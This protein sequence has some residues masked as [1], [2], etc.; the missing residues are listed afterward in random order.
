MATEDARDGQVLGPTTWAV[1]CALRGGASSRAD[2]CLVLQGRTTVAGVVSALVLLKKRGLVD[3]P[4]QRGQWV[5][6]AAGAKARLRPPPAGQQRHRGAKGQKK[7]RTL[8]ARRLTLREQEEGRALAHVDTVTRPKT[9]GDCQGGVRPCPW[10]GCRWHLYLDVNPVS[11]SILFNHPDTDPLDL[12]HTCALDV[13]DG[14]GATLE[15]VGDMVGLTRERVRQVEV[16][17]LERL[18]AKLPPGMR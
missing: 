17:L 11:G 7:G 8:P 1:V 2:L 5:L 16:V 14:G 18:R 4:G 9:R 15:R 6:T 13:A 12:V 10:V 3:N